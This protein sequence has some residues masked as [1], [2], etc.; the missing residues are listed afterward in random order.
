MAVN[1][2]FAPDDFATILSRYDL[3][4]IIS[5]EAIQQGTVQTNY[6]LR[7]A[8]GR[9][10]FRYYENRSRESVLFES[11]L[12]THLG[13]R[14]YPCPAQVPNARGAYVG[15]YHGK[16]YVVFEFIE[17]QSVEQPAPMHKRQLI[18]KAAELQRMTEGFRSRY[19]PYR[20]H[21]DVDLCRALARRRA[22]YL[23]TRG[24][25]DKLAWLV[26]TLR[27]LDLPPSLPKGICHCDFH[28]SNV[29]FRGDVFVA[30]LDFDDANRT[31]LSFDLAGLIDHWAWPH[32]ADLLDLAEA[33]GIVRVYVEHRRLS[34]PERRHLFDVYKLSILFDCI[35]Y[36]GR[37]AADDCRERRK[38]DAL[39][40]LG[41][42][43][44]YRALFPS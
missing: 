14:G 27:K 17:G 23:D 25:L 32:K 22:A 38:I 40:S 29:L 37:G 43:A 19:A 9:F 5:A 35:W 21:Y 30:L 34:P 18:Q 39:E 24:A 8:R 2:V 42:E 36:F 7:T 6:L 26:H 20:W 12:L 4:A 1:T 15:T 3:G 11:D 10:V 13:E 16:P 28:P 44:F 33:R 31:F 41:R